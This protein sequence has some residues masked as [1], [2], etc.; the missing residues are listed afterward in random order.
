V[1]I[2]SAKC[3][4]HG[5]KDGSDGEECEVLKEERRENSRQISINQE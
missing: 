3:R 1:S 5:Y 4:T 2:C